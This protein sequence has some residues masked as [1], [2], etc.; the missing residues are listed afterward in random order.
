MQREYFQPLS[1]MIVDHVDTENHKIAIQMHYHN[2]YEILFF[3]QATA[4]FMAGTEL[5]AISDGDVVFV[6]PYTLHTAYELGAGQ[7]KRYYINIVTGFLEQYARRFGIEDILKE[8]NEHSFFRLRTG[9]DEALFRRMQERF[10][11]I[12]RQSEKQSGHWQEIIYAELLL[13]LSDLHDSLSIPEH[14]NPHPLEH[15]NSSLRKT[16]DF[17]DQN[18]LND[19]TLA[20][21]SGNLYLSRCYICRM[22]RKH[23][24][25]TVSQYINRKKTMIAQQILNNEGA[26]I[27]EACYSS[28]FNHMQYFCKVFEEITGFTPSQYIRNV[29]NPIPRQTR[30]YD[31]HDSI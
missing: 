25:L 24:G 9:N 13:L 30:L 11:S 19:I 27:T 7:Y 5:Y 29:R 6:Q 31:R 15:N 28:G 12:R 4:R 22:F 3:E 26:T 21:L 2:G 23:T 1:A 20:D 14:K 16:L 10:S 18:F 17:I 8:L